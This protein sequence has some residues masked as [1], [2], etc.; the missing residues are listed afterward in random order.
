MADIQM[1][2]DSLTIEETNKV[3]LSLGLTPIGGPVPEGEDA[4]VDT[5]A[6]AEANY[7][8]RRGEMKKAKEELELKEKIAKCVLSLCFP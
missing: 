5:D 1:N 6:I 3:R 8:E 4:P 2:A 7:A